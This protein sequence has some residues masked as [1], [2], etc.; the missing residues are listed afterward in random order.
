MDFGRV[1]PGALAQ[2]GFQL[3]ADDPRTLLA[4]ARGAASAHLQLRLGCPVWAIK[5]WL[6]R[7]YPEG[8]LNAEF[9]HHYSR[10][11]TSIELNAT[12]YRMPGA[13]TIAR[14][15]DATPPTFRFCPKFPQEN[16]RRGTL[17]E[18]AST[19]KEFV[20][21]VLAL[22][23]RLGMTFL[24]LP[25]SFSPADLPELRKFLESL[26]R[27]FQLAVEVRHPA[28]FR[29]HTLISPFLLPPTDRGCR[30]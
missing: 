11:F 3:A 23:G 28:F 2:I 12:H 21:L 20:H 6:G 22:E 14:W 16:S 9:L 30:A 7:V 19:T 5:S 4:L 17:L 10:S 15:I 13:A 1:A 26:P 24:Q 29:K 8:T 25:P 18:N 27:G